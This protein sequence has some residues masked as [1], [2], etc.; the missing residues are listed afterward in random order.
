MGV[1]NLFPMSFIKAP[2]S[3]VKQLKITKRGN[4]FLLDFIPE[5]CS[6]F[7]AIM[8]I[9]TFTRLDPVFLYLPPSM[10]IMVFMPFHYEQVSYLPMSVI[11][12]TFKRENVKRPLEGFGVLIPSKEQQN[13]LRTLGN[14]IL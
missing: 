2:L 9:Y 10:E 3:A 14:V 8:V 12:T 6:L 13:G 7:A 5:V 11:I 4:P 1:Y